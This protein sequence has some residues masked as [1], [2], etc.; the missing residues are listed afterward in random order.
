MLIN[1]RNIPAIMLT[2]QIGTQNVV[3]ELQKWGYTTFDDP[4]RFGPAI[5][6]GGGD[7]RLI[8]HA[9]AYAVFASGGMYNRHEVIS[10][11]EDV[12]GNV[13]YEY[14][15]QPQQIADPRGIYLVNDILN[16]KKG[17]VGYS[18]DGRDIAGKT[19]TSEKQTETLFVTYT[20]EIVA[21]GWL[22]NNT[23][24][25]MV[26]G[27]TGYTSARP[28]VSEYVQRMGD[29]IPATAFKRPEGV[30]YNSKG[31]LAIRGIAAPLKVSVPR[32]YRPGDVLSLDSHYAR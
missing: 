19:G 13:L 27:A 11:I 32:Q 8:E 2:D 17:G 1:S 20:P 4:N 23:N 15:P 26:Y 14:K 31:H 16:G 3:A 6:V 5:S 10:R 7:V 21:I 9:Q 29:K 12:D 18:F 22:G 30:Y 25:G 28:W 24:K